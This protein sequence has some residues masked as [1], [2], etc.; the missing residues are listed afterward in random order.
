MRPPCSCA[1]IIARVERSRHAGLRTREPQAASPTLK[2]QFSA[3]RSSSISRPASRPTWQGSAVGLR[4]SRHRLVQRQPGCGS[5]IEARRSFHSSQ[6]ARAKNP[7]D[8]LGVDA[9][10]STSDIKKAYYGL[11]KKFHPDTNKDATAKTRFVEIQD[12]YDTLSD[13][14]KRSA[15]DKYG[16]ASQQQGFDADAYARASSSFGGGSSPFGDFF[17]G[18]G[19]GNASGASSDLFE[20]LFGAFGGGSR[21]RPGQ[22]GRRS[23]RVDMTGSDVETEITIP[24]LDACKGTSRK[25]TIQPVVNCHVC[26]GSGTKKGA[27]KTTCSACQGSGSMS[28]VVQGGFTM[29]TTCQQCGGAGES[30]KPQDMCGTCGGVGKVRER[31]TVDV[32]V[33]A[34][35]DDGQMVRLDGQGDA[36][37]EGSGKP[38]HLLVRI[39]VIPSKT[40]RRQGANIYRD[41][42]LPF[43]TAVLGGRARVPTLEEEVEVRIPPGTQPDEEMLLRGR[44]IKKLYK[45]QRGDLLL[46]FK[47]SV[48]RSLT[49][50]QR[51]ILEDYAADIEGRPKPSDTKPAEPEATVV[52]ELAFQDVWQAALKQARAEV[53][54]SAS[55]PSS[56]SAAK[57]EQTADQPNTDASSTSDPPHPP[58][59]TAPSDKVHGQDGLMS[60]AGRFLGNMF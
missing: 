44:G 49:A 56:A 26:T 37:L 30:V 50:S 57:P 1:S 15:F 48:P 51:A 13:D 35:V 10:A 16:A 19:A 36:P 55:A 3:S 41:T 4:G 22:A 46:K 34:G 21:G 11:A 24:F 5:T 27:K 14:S 12:A 47:I 17:A 7:Y 58:S 28:F 54:A 25:V 23:Q 2:R 60:R 42:T 32:E 6:P 52:D 39:N 20:S 8:V 33:P 38:G 43:H 45:Q 40:F 9:K 31:K 59:G 29:S 53:N 18:G